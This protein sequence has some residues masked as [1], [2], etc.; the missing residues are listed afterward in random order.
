MLA[1]NLVQVSLSGKPVLTYI[2]KVNLSV[3]S[4]NQYW[5]WCL[6]RDIFPIATYLSGQE[7]LV[8]DFLFRDSQLPSEWASRLDWGMVQ[9]YAFPP[10]ALIFRILRLFG[11]TEPRFLC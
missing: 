7:N 3:A 1:C 2:N 11:R 6:S 10:I 8:A 5:R 9:G 4:L